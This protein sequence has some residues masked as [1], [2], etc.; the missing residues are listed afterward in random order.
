MGMLPGTIDVDIACAGCE[1]SLRGLDEFGKCPEC[2]MVIA[3]SILEARRRAYEFGPPLGIE[4]AR[5]LRRIGSAIFIFLTGAIIGGL[6]GIVVQGDGIVFFGV[7]AVALIVQFAGVW[8]MTAALPEEN[9]GARRRRWASRIALL[10][11][12]LI[13]G[14][15]L[16]AAV[17]VGQQ[18]V[19]AMAFPWVVVYWLASGMGSVF[20]YLYLS[21]LA[22]RSL[23][24]GYRRAA[25]SMGIA[26]CWMVASICVVGE[27]WYI[28]SLLRL[29]PVPTILADAPFLGPVS[30]F[31]A[32]LIYWT[33]WGNGWAYRITVLPG[34]VFVV[35][36]I[37]VL[38]SFGMSLLR[39]AKQLESS[40]SNSAP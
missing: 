28:P 36:A 21:N 27:W 6:F 32:R 12:Y 3:E 33:W 2:A 29:F 30:T 17:T 37:T 1:Y 24:P 18:S 11:A 9:R 34:M 15:I 4:S 39:L 10:M 26:S 31:F 40:S 25:W 38:V 5:V 8:L 22:A 35:S 16:I 19:A 13:L 23:L 7:L 14:S 20:G